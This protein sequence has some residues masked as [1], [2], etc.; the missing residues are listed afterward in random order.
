MGFGWS[1]EM[2]MIEGKLR[3]VHDILQDSLLADGPQR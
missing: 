3:S 2:A 1:R